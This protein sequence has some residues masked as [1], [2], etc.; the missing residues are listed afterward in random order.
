ME[1][2]FSRMLSWVN[3]FT[4]IIL[5]LIASSTHGQK[6]YT[7]SNL[8]SVVAD[9]HKVAILPFVYIF[10]RTKLPEGINVDFLRKM[11][12]EEGYRAQLN[13]YDRILEKKKLKYSVEFQDVHYTNSLLAKTGLDYYAL[14][15]IDYSTLK[16]ILGVDAV[17]CGRVDNVDQDKES[18]FF[19]SP[20]SSPLGGNWGTN[21][22][23]AI[24]I[25]ETQAGRLLWKMKTTSFKYNSTTTSIIVKPMI[26]NLLY[27]IPYRKK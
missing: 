10:D 19:F 20:H 27:E 16:E 3:Q 12:H 6:I 4:V 8:D 26:D 17:I 18:V 1:W 22:A 15:T 11:E 21:M 14:E 7:S 25:Y 23:V 24:N 5:V 9:H 13:I 2:L